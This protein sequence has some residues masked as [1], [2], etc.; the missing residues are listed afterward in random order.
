MKVSLLENLQVIGSKIIKEF[1]TR[2]TV[3]IG[4]DLLAIQ[5]TN[6]LINASY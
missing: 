3:K 2:K 4:L 1:Q 5:Y 6:L